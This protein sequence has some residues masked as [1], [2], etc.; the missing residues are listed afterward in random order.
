MNAES[1]STS[2]IE[3]TAQRLISTFAR[4]FGDSCSTE[5]VGGATEP[6]YEPAGHAGLLHRLY[7]RDDYF[8]SALH[9]V[10][11]WCIAGEARRQQRDFGYWYAPDGRDQ[12]Q[13]SAFEAV[14]YK[15]QA[16]EWLFCLA[17]AFPFQISFD[18]LDATGSG[19]PDA[20]PFKQRIYKQAQHWA[21]HGLPSRA[22]LFFQALSEEFGTQLDPGSLTLTLEELR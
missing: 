2:A 7:F 1:L 17:C 20:G 22:A 12:A 16:L 14:E 4:C 21:Q 10:S 18:N 5:L 11:H 13:Q 15:P 6:L 19:M 8:A 9:E 3:H